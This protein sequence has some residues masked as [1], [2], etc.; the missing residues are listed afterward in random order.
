MALSIFD[1]K[2]NLPD[3]KELLSVL[4][5]TY[6]HWTEIK[7]FLKEEYSEV[8]GEWKY[9]GKNY[10]WGFRLRDKKRVVVYLTPCDGYFKFSILFCEKATAEALNS[11]ISKETK[12]NIESSKVYA[13]GRGIRIDVKDSKPIKDIKKLIVIKLQ[14]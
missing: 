6:K 10:G 12:I 4:E 8:T 3:Q 11:N 7:E 13:E 5:N 2:K 1:N 14:H 9:V